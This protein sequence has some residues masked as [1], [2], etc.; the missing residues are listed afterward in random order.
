M[1]GPIFG[2]SDGLDRENTSKL[3]S[4]SL[5]EGGR[6]SIESA[7]EPALFVSGAGRRGPS[8]SSAEWVTRMNRAEE[9]TWL[10][11]RL[12]VIPPAQSRRLVV[13]MRASRAR[14]EP[15]FRRPTNSQPPMATF[16]Q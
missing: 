3:E 10:R 2:G 12:G 13:R 8:K 15:I 4:E 14:A 7:V 6:F 16:P 9:L 11:R 5:Y 1:T